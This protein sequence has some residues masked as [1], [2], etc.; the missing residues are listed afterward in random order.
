MSE[1]SIAAAKAYLYC[2]KN[3]ISIYLNCY[4]N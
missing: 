1:T 2:C 3:I 4:K